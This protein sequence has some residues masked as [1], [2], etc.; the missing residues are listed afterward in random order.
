MSAESMRERSGGGDGDGRGRLPLVLVD[1]EGDFGAV[2]KH[3]VVADGMSVSKM[4]FSVAFSIVIFR[5][6]ECGSK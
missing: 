6:L 5:K 1:V 2:T 3:G 4:S